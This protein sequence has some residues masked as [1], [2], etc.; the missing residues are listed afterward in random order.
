MSKHLAEFGGN[1]DGIS[2]FITHH[3]M[4]VQLNEHTKQRTK[5]NFMFWHKLRNGPY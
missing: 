1:H 5:L 4:N 3:S 2:E